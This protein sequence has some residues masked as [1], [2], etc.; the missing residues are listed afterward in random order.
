MGARWWGDDC[1]KHLKVFEKAHFE[2]DSVQRARPGVGE[3]EAS[4][5]VSGLEGAE[6]ALLSARCWLTNCLIALAKSL[7]RSEER[8][9]DVFAWVK[10]LSFPSH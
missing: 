8:D 2:V 5:G 3:D 4:V 9:G 7:L 1:G 6:P 10:T